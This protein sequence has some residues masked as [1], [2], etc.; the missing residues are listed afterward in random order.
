MKEND[1]FLPLKKKKRRAIHPFMLLFLMLLPG[2]AEAQYKAQLNINIKKGTLVDVFENIQKQSEYRFMYSTQDVTPITNITIQRKGISVQEVLDFVLKGHE[3]TYLVEG[4]IIFIKKNHQAQFVNI[5]GKVSDE[6]G[7]PLIGATILIEGTFIGTTT[8]INGNYVFTV[9]KKENMNI[10]YSFIGMISQ[11]VTYIGQDNIDVVLKES[12]KTIDEV[13]ITGY[14]TLRKSDVVGSVST[15]KASDFMMPVYTSVA[16]MLQGRV[17]GML[18]MNTSSRVGTSPK[19]RIRGTSTIL[20]NQDPLWV[21]DG[22]IQPDP[23]PLNQNDLMVDDLKNI[24]GNQI[25]WLNPAD[26]ETVTVLK[27]ASAT[28]IYGS[29]AANG[30]IVI[31][32]R[33]GKQ[34]S[35]T[36]NYSGTFSFRSRPHYGLFNLMNSQERIQFSREAFTAGAIY[37][38]APIASINTYEGIMSMLYNKTITPQEAES[39][40]HRLEQTNT[41]WFNILTRNSFSHNHNLSVS[42]GSEKI[43]YN[44]SLGYSNQSGIE[45]NNDA[46]NLS[47]RINLGISL[48]PKIHIDLS[49]VGSINKTWGYAAN[50]SPLE[51]ATKTSRSILAYNEDGSRHFQEIRTNYTYNENPVILGYNI[52]NEIDHSYS[53]NKSSQINGNLNFAYDILPWLKYEF[54]GGINN[55]AGDSEAYAGEQSYYITSTYRGYDFGTEAYGSEKY[56]AAILP[57]GGELYNGN[58]DVQGWNIQNKITFS[59]TFQEDHRLNILIGTE[60][61]STKTENK[62]QKTFG[63]VKERGESIVRPTPLNELI[64][65]GNR[66]SP[67]LGL[68]ENLYNGSGWMRNTLTANQFSVFATLAYSFKNRYVIN[69][70]M[71]N[72]ASNRFG[73]DQNKRFDPTFSF[74]VSWNVTQE[75]CLQNISNII[76]QFNLRAS[77]GIQGN[78]VNSISPELILKMDAIKPYYGDYMSKISRIPNPHLSWER[79]KTWNFGLDIQVIQWISMNIEYYTKKSN[80]IVNQSI[81]L[82]YGRVGTEING[83]RIVNSGIEYTLNITPIRT[84][85]WGWTIGFNSSKNWNEAKTQSI[86]EINLQ[87]YIS[88]SSDKVLKEGFAL[89]SFWSYDFKKLSSVD[90]SP[91]FNRL[92]QEDSQG[93]ILKS[94]DGSPLLKNVSEYTDMLVYSGKMEPD[95]T[96]GLTTRLRWKGLT[97]GANFSLLLGAK[98]RLPNPYPD[99]GNIPLSNVN[100]SKNLI[101]RWKKTGDETNTYIPGIYIG[102]IANYW[103]LQDG[104]TYNMYQMWGESDI[105]VANANF[106]RCQQMSLTWTANDKICARMKVKSFS[107]NAI[108]NNVF[109]VADKKFHGFDPELGDSV[110]PKTYSFGITVGF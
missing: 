88:G 36:V 95:F 67:G 39:A 22:V 24:L 92:F 100:L 14:Q 8:D 68:F 108:M 86:S 52:L 53:L 40:I 27:D 96:G 46:R 32:T 21:V 15:V 109:V 6:N 54:V 80:N 12:I 20:G 58:S 64:P 69:A 76:N 37:N 71:R 66:P 19:I 44:I 97:F 18:V 35:L 56:K 93:N 5:K 16:Q 10:L 23:I 74:G 99:L 38:E 62:S 83:G 65:I 1:F 72:D 104:R 84:K 105:M 28:A 41:D 29:K 42:G 106:L 60:V 78:A 75:P 101:N 87:D 61:T 51:Y 82:E 90:G 11:K 94:E 110:Q 91:E 48:N 70:S 63:Y 45:I 33:R 50:I 57:S 34:E 3:L 7:E 25:S 17:A 49:L 85:D 107:I 43:I 2:L 98:K 81:A 103:R 79:T 4:K 9:P 59:K 30:V 102:R 77:Y 89:S 55:N 13:V 31:T 73:Q 26:I 47:G